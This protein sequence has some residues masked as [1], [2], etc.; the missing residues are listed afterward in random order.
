MSIQIL[1]EIEGGIN[2]TI[3]ALRNKRTTQKKNIMFCQILL[4]TLMLYKLRENYNK[5]HCTAIL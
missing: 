2:W 3:S 4:S 1:L 5:A